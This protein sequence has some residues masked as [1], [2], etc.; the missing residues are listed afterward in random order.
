AAAAKQPPDV[1][2]A[3][4]HLEASERF[5]NEAA[6]SRRADAA[7]V[8]KQRNDIAQLRAQLTTILLDL[9]K[10]DAKAAPTLM[11]YG[12]KDAAFIADPGAAKVWRVPTSQPQNAAAFT[13]Q[14]APEGV[15][16]PALGA[17][18]GAVLYILER[19]GRPFR[20]DGHN[21]AEP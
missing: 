5:L 3:R 9:V 15:G 18:A 6:A 4:E 12:Q 19:D 13:Q 20:Y 17:L 10:L 1:S 21:N 14:G 8:A 11:D 2:A 16:F 7:Q